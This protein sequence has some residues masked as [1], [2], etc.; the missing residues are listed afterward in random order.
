MNPFANRTRRKYSTCHG[1]TESNMVHGGFWEE[2]Q[3]FELYPP[4]PSPTRPSSSIMRNWRN[5]LNAADSE[6]CTREHSDS[7]LRTGTRCSCLVASR[8]SDPNVQRGYSTILGDSRSC[9]CSLHCGIRRTLKTV[10]L[11]MLTSS[12]SRNCL[13][14]AQISYVNQRIVEG[15][16]DVCDT[17]ALNSFLL[18]HSSS[19]HDCLKEGK[20]FLAIFNFLRMH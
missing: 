20:T 2:K 1:D 9:P 14:P 3:G 4:A 19:P 15:G 11:N 6:T 5:I 7:R 16:I 10:S 17:P 13:S 8:S 12:A 18:R